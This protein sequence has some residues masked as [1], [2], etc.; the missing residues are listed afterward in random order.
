MAEVNLDLL[1]SHV[2]E[3]NALEGI[4]AVGFFL[5]QRFSDPYVAPEYFL[6]HIEA[7]RFVADSPL[8]AIHDPREVHRRLFRELG[9]F[10]GVYRTTG[11]VWVGDRQMPKARHVPKL[12]QEWVGYAKKWA[13]DSGAENA[14]EKFRRS[15]QL[16]NLFLVIHPFEDGNG[17]TARLLLN[18]L[19]LS[20]GLPWLVIYGGNYEFY[21]G[22][23]VA[24]E[25]LF[26]KEYGKVY[27]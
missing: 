17:R 18:A 15:L 12:M 20:M 16:H 19:R 9:P 5:G 1:R 27:E 6:G 13:T 4:G 24:F 25:E 21:R 10:A 7:A 22:Q 23:L 11:E 3:S 2:R 14:D 8:L 26:R